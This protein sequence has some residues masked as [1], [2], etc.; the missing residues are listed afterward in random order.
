[1]KKAVVWSALAALVTLGVM[2]GSAMSTSIDFD[3]AGER[4]I[5][6]VLTQDISV[7]A[8]ANNQGATPSTEPATI[9]LLG[10][11]LAGLA[12]MARRRK[13]S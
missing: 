3:A 11:G 6:P 2:A 5:D 12:G 13:M 4:G 9:L 7:V 1:M 8:A 10:T